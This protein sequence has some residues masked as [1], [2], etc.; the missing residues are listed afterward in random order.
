MCNL[1][2][3]MFPYV[4]ECNVRRDS[5]FALPNEGG[6]LGKGPLGKA[7]FKEPPEGFL[8]SKASDELMRRPSDEGNDF[9]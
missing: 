8:S 4:Y 1:L 5:C 6:W 3:A 7:C 9:L 2:R